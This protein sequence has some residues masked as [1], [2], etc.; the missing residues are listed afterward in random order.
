MTSRAAEP[1]YDA[2]A[3]AVLSRAALAVRRPRAR[4][5]RCRGAFRWSSSERQ[6]ACR[7]TAPRLQ[8]V[9]GGRTQRRR[10]SGAGSGCS[11]FG[12]GGGRGVRTTRPTDRTTPYGAKTAEGVDRAVVVVP[13]ALRWP[14]LS[15]QEWPLQKLSKYSS[16][17]RKKPIP[18]PGLSVVDARIPC[19]TTAFDDTGQHPVTST[20]AAV[21]QQLR[22]VADLGLWTLRPAET[23]TN[24]T[25]LAQLRHQITELELRHAHQADQLDLGAEAGATDTGS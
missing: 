23:E 11:R 6:R 5:G 8:V 24:L 18:S 22:E 4:A 13:P 17:C 1:A 7:D 9:G 10:R 14:S 2:G 19:M 12:Y 3:W 20:I 16:T 25:A 15:T 21:S